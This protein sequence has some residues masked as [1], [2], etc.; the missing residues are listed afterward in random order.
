M[1][2]EYGHLCGH[3]QDRGISLGK[4]FG[5]LCNRKSPPVPRGTPSSIPGPMSRINVYSEGITK[6]SSMATHPRYWTIGRLHSTITRVPYV[7]DYAT[8]SLLHI[9][10]RSTLHQYLWDGPTLVFNTW[11]LTPNESGHRFDGSPGNWRRSLT[12]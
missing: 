9:N 3:A 1:G 5:V 6:H 11:V 10:V 2:Q 8:Q 4:S 12:S 7:H